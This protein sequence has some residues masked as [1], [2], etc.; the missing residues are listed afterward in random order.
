MERWVVSSPSSFPLPLSS[1]G[2]HSRLLP[3]PILSLLSR[4]PPTH[5]IRLLRYPSPEGCKHLNDD[6]LP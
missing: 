3:S 4:P 1:L 5:E 2:C 6:R